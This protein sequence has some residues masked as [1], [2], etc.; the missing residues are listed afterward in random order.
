[1]ASTRKKTVLTIKEKYLALKDLEKGLT[2]KNVAE[3]FSVLQNTLTYW[4][5]YK[6][7][8]ISKYEPGQF[9]AKGKKLIVGEYD[10]VDK[11]VYKWF[12]N[13]RERNVPVGG[14]MI[15]KKALGFAKEL[16]ITDFKASEGSLDP[17]KNRHSNCFWRRKVVYRGND[18][19]LGADPFTHDPLKI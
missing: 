15:R 19:K 8:I 13:A 4:I 3:K 6:E 14:H 11:A 9:G 18:S 12:M 10:S 16:N 7:D 5:K 17:W 2:K 1:M